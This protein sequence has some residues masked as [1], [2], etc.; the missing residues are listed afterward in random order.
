MALLPMKTQLEQRRGS[1]TLHSCPDPSEAVMVLL[2]AVSGLGLDSVHCST[3]LRDRRSFWFSSFPAASLLPPGSSAAAGAVFT[4]HT[5]ISAARDRFCSCNGH[6]VGWCGGGED[7]DVA[8]AGSAQRRRAEHAGSPPA[9]LSP[10][11]EAPPEH[12]GR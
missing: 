12:D 4:S 2:A 1:S 6:A 7:N 9:L 3:F 10:G 5:L 8:L 11:D